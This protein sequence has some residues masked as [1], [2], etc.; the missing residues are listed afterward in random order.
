VFDCSLSLSLL[1]LIFFF[2]PFPFS[3][4]GGNEMRMG[5]ASRK[6]DCVPSVGKFPHCARLSLPHVFVL[7][8]FSAFGPSSL[9]IFLTSI[10]CI[11]FQLFF[12]RAGSLR[13]HFRAAYELR[14]SV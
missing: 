10:A 3:L 8:P 14:R 5:R 6:I 12:V 11:V 1:F 9:A 7:S 2:A 13:P 4:A